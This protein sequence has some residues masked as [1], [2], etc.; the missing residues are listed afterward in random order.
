MNEQNDFDARLRQA[1]QKQGLEKADAAAAEGSQALPGS[2]LR[3]GMRAG[4]EV[5]SALI[6]GSGLGW[7]LDRWLGTFPWLFMLF[8]VVGGA[9]GVLNVYRLFNPRNGAPR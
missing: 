8:F 6:A 7:L 1:R 2:A 4:V 9:A 3:I 5:V